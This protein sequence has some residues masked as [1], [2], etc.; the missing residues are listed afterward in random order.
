MFYDFSLLLAILKTCRAYTLIN[1]GILIEHRTKRVNVANAVSP[2]FPK[3]SMC[4]MIF[5]NYIFRAREGDL[6]II[7]HCLQKIGKAKKPTKT[8]SFDKIPLLT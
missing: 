5:S 7:E 2:I 6:K 1:R 8:E 4:S 3:C